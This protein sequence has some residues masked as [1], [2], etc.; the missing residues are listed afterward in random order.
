MAWYDFLT[1][2]RDTEEKLNPSQFVI[3]RDQGME[4]LSRENVTNYRNAYEQLE[5]VNRAV[6]M[7]VDDSAEIPF[8]VGEAI[9]GLQSV[10]KGVRRSKVDLL[11]NIQPNPF[12]DVSTF[13]R[14]LIIDLLID[15]N[16]FVYF[17]GAHLYHLPADHVTI[18]TDDNTYIEKFTYDHSIDYSPSEIIHIKENS[19]NSIYRGVP[20]LKPAFRTMQ[21]LGSM[22]NFQDNFFKNGAVPGLVLKSPNTLSEKIKERM[23]SSWVARYNPQ[24]GGRRP[25]FLDGGLEVENLTEVN[26]KDLDF[27]DGI[28]AN[29]KIILEALGIPPIL[30]DGGNN[31][32]IRP[33]HRLYYLETIM[34]ITN[35]IAC[36]FE[37]FFGFKLD[38]EVSGIPALQPELKDQAAYFA[39]LVNTGIFTPN[40][41]REALRLEKID[42]FDTPRVP[43]NIAGSAANPAEGGRPPEETEE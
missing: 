13:K 43:A 2:N 26:F 37:R 35:K 22:R 18:H 36:A 29:E 1:G 38:E 12:Q 30:M 16:I 14:N 7:I 6:N 10:V 41:A 11:L 33:N 5:V 23:L 42:G 32:N 9:T 39:T 25:L 15:G 4:V 28:K 21:L 40:E 3:A 34:P 24:S 17:D 19:F 8:D 27:Q 31:A 20:R